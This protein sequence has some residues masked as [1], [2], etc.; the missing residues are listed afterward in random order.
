MKAKEKKLFRDGL[1][2]GKK[3]LMFGS[4]WEE[5]ESVVFPAFEKLL[6]SNKDVIMI[7]APHEPTVLHIE[8][9][10][11]YFA[12]KEKTIRFSSKNNYNG[13][14][15]VIIDSIGILLTLYFYADVA[16]VGGSFKINVHNVLEP[17]VYGIPVLFGPK[18]W[19]SI[20]ANELVK[21]GASQIITNANEA[22]SILQKLFDDDEY[23]AKI[24][25]ISST[26]VNENLGA[27]EI[28]IGEIE[29]YL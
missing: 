1:F 4:S 7:I 23:R 24:G 12:K 10:E 3:I 11:N 20:E 18:I 5:D 29:K 2:E 9:I 21:R 27:S 28:I 26:Y 15:I 6:E 14:R 13:E 19:N 17:A 22:Y 16:F 25:K 8:Q